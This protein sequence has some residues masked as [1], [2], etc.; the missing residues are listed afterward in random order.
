MDRV[1]FVVGPG[2]CNNE[3]LTWI[4]NHSPDTGSRRQYAWTNYYSDWGVHKRAGCDWMLEQYG[5]DLMEGYT[6]SGLRNPKPPHLLNR[7]LLLEWLPKL[8]EVRK[9]SIA[10]YFNV[11]NI[12]QSIDFIKSQDWPFEVAVAQATWNMPKSKIRHWHIMMELDP[13]ACDDDRGYDIR[14]KYDLPFL[15]WAVVDRHNSDWGFNPHKDKLDLLA[16]QS[17]GP[18]DAWFEAV[19]LTPPPAEELAEAVNM[20][21]TLNETKDPDL[22]A[23]NN[24]NWSDIEQQYR[25]CDQVEFHKLLKPTLRGK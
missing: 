4:L 24:M 11:L 9:E 8:H 2:H 7:E 17:K 14:D 5:T 10:L 22:I 3:Y 21:H 16:D 19:G 25:K 1:V 12:E 23:I 18:S 15:A 20:Y 6:R 13:F